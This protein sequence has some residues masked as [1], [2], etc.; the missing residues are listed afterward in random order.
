MARNIILQ[1]KKKVLQQQRYQSMIDGYAHEQKV[2]ITAD[3]MESKITDELF[4][5]QATTGLATKTSEHW[6]W[7]V[8]T[9]DPSRI[10]NPQHYYNSETGAQER[11][12]LKAQ[13]RSSK[14]ILAQDF[15][16]PMIGTSE[17]RLRY[18]Q[19]VEELADTFADVEP[20]P[21]VDRY[22]EYVSDESIT[23]PS[24]AS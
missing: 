10:M 14:T 1:K 6:R 5:K 9:L 7:Q 4:A 8:I 15:L 12:E 24:V 17:D 13:L 20:T 21:E 16:N 18:K 23:L 3:N 22:F 2:W 11:L 19:L